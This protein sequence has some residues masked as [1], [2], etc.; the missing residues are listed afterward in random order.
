MSKAEPIADKYCRG[1]LH[2]V[3]KPLILLLICVP[4]TL[5]ILAPIG[6][7]IGTGMALA[8]N[9]MQVKAGWLTLGLYSA[10]MPLV[11]MSGMHYAVV[12]YVLNNLATVGYD[13]LQLPAMLAPNLGQAAACAAV[14]I[15]TKNKDLK[16]VASASAIS[17]AT[18]G[19]T[20]PALYGVT[21][22]LKKPLLASMIGSGIA[23]V[24]IGIVGLKSYAFV[25]PSF[26]AMP[27][28]I[29]SEYVM[30]FVFACIAAVISI[31]VTFVITLALGWDDKVDDDSIIE[32]NNKVLE[33]SSQ[34]FIATPLEGEV[35]PLSEV[36]DATFASGVLGYGIAIKPSKGVVYAPFDGTIQAFFP[37]LHALGLVDDQKG[38]ELLIHVGLETVNLNGE[39]FYAKAKQG[40]SFKKGDVLLEFDLEKLQNIGFDMITPIIVTNAD[41]YKIVENSKSKVVTKNNNIMEV[42]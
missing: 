35:V 8:L 4:V 14:A 28:F 9:W 12:P 34:L 33:T 30:N 41:T 2:I 1:W 24:F 11:I 23:G 40:D 25:S 39:G 20:E 22:K 6:T 18:A 10:M 32:D 17:A 29:S 16:A 15:R 27:M 5:I 37:T 36:N 13:T 21:M 7:W 19:I 38:V 42:E 31:V 3:V 26:L